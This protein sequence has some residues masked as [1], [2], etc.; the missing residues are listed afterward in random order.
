MFM[1]G[2]T[3]A[4]QL[5]GHVQ[6]RVSSWADP[7][8]VA[9]TTGYQLVQSLY[10]IGT[11]GFAG[12]GLGLGSPQKIPNAATDFVFSAIGEELGL[13]GTVAVCMLF[14]LFVGSG[15]R[16]A[17]QA[18]RPFSKLFA[19]GLTTIVGVQTF[20]IVGGVIRVI[21]L[22]GVTLP[23]ISYG[24]SSLVANFV[25]VALLLRISDETVEH[26]E[27]PR[28]VATARGAGPRLH[29]SV[30]AHDE[31]RD[32]E[33]RDRGERAAPRPDRSAHL[34]PGGR[35]DNLADDPR[36][37]RNTLA[38][39]NRPRGNIVHRRRCDP[40]DV[41]EAPGP[42][43][44]QVPAHLPGR[45][46]LRPDRGLPVVP[47]GQH[48]GGGELRH[49]CS[50]G[51]TRRSSS[52]TSTRCS[53]ATTDTGNVVLSSSQKAQQAARDA[54]ADQRGSVVAINVK[55]GE[56]V[57]MFSNPTFD[58]NPLTSH[59]PQAAQAAFEALRTNPD[60]PALPRA[61]REIYPPGS[62]FKIV[63]SAAAL[64]S[65]LGITPFDPV[66]PFVSEIPLPNSGGQTLQNFGGEV[67]GGNL[68]ESLVHSCN[69]TFGQVGLQL[70][71]ALVPGINN[72]GVGVGPPPFDLTP[73]AVGSTGPA[74]GTFQNDQ[75]G[76]AKAAI[77]QQDVAVTPLEMALAAAGIANGGVIMAPHVVHEIQNADGSVAKT[78][79]NTPWRTC[80]TP[81]HARALTDMMVAVVQRGTGTAAR[82]PGVTV[83]GKTGTA[84]TVQG[85]AP[86]VVHRRSLPPRTRSTRSR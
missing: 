53:R 85:A 27:M 69:T 82:I 61:Y 83:A 42:R 13:L 35:R 40:C 49:A 12:T 45:R 14:L 39:F 25:V 1:V 64:D 60:N 18:E 43:R 9:Q 23:F 46:P 71:N 58:P 54:L 28:R 59:D 84:Q 15:F 65:T 32:Q 29:R 51:V 16:V 72:C 17:V 37:V 4:Y 73:G 31:R 55:T 56:I 78:I 86:R 5:F 52:T 10:A 48:R 20:V 26:Q 67:C 24:G 8:S 63:T 44:L 30:E 81:Q 79:P 2:A 36:N 6:E 50:P 74:P 68:T 33:G 70:G 22:T 19:A 34:P 62:S 80:V 57:A 41:D 21:P 3:I 66:Y 38:A 77:G 7:W 11:G 75:P 47:A 76:F